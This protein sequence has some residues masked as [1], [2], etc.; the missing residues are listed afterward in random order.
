MKKFCLTL[1]KMKKEG[2][3]RVFSPIINLLIAKSIQHNK[4]HEAAEK[5]KDWL[6]E[7]LDDPEKDRELGR[8][9]AQAL[10]VSLYEKPTV[11]EHMA[12]MT[13][14]QRDDM[15]RAAD[16]TDEWFKVKDTS[17]AG[18]HIS[19][20]VFYICN[21]K[22]GDGKCST[23][24]T[25]GNWARKFEDPLATKQVWYCTV[26]GAKY[27]VANGVMIEMVDGG[28]HRYLRASFPEHG[29]QQVK[30]TAIQE[31]HSTA[32][33][34]Q[35]LLATIPAAAIHP[36]SVI[37]PIPGLPGSYTFHGPA[38]DNVP[39]FEWGKLF[40]NEFLPNART[41]EGLTPA[42]RA[43]V[44]CAEAPWRKVPIASTAGI[45]KEDL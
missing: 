44:V 30:W 8:Q 4:A 38:F 23:L 28:T 20:R 9:A 34:P 10:H 13:P 16:Y 39:H 41:G 37:Q 40:S 25:S 19:L 26:C 45:A 42:Q 1:S 7:G 27:K 2:M 15:D 5:Y 17:S 18:G 43:K 36:N 22:I 33:T 21:R 24:I 32:A 31:A 6:A 29:L 35:D 12:K 3:R 14:A 11:P